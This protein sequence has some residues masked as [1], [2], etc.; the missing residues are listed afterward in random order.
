ME[1]MEGDATMSRQRN[2]QGRASA[3]GRH[4]GMT[5][6][7][8]DPLVNECGAKSTRGPR[9][10]CHAPIVSP[11]KVE[12]WSDVVC[13]WC[14]IGKVRFD[15]A[16]QILRDKGISAPIDV[17]YKSF[18]L[19]PTAPTGPG[20]PARDAYAKKFGGTERAQQI[21][22]HVT[23]VAAQDGIEFRM[24]IA[25][26]ANTVLA[27]RALHYALTTHGAEIQAAYKTAL[28]SAYFTEGRDIGDLEVV[29]DCATA[30]GLDARDL[31]EWIDNGGGMDEFRAD[32]EAAAARDITAV[33]SFV[34]DD[35]FLIPG[36][37]DV[38]VFVNVLERV[39][40]Q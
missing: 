25:L 34:I 23:N 21:L 35:R 10:V 4:H 26:R 12:I 8:T 20:T 28:L 11:V 6:P 14:Y 27:H 30:V 2:S 36:A 24:D 39:L 13:P 16:V 33:P 18:Q 22:D 1:Q 17:E 19:D 32:L 37:Q 31:A 38:D 9:D 7:V 5:N 40:A 3:S 29:S 15:K